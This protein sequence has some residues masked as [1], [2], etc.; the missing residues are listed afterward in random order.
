MENT[1]VVAPAP[2]VAPINPEYFVVIE[3]DHEGVICNHP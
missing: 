3:E 2:V 1:I